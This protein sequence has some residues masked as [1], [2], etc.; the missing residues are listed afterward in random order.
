M[1]M[2][3]HRNWSKPMI[4]KLPR[5]GKR[6]GVRQSKK[7]IATKPDLKPSPI[8]NFVEH[9]LFCPLF[10]IIVI[11]FP[12]LL[13]RSPYLVLEISLQTSGFWDRWFCSLLLLILPLLEKLLLLLGWIGKSSPSIV[14]LAFSGFK[15]WRSLLGSFCLLIH[16]Q[17]VL[18]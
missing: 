1:I 4:T 6:N 2:T 7:K 8:S 12:V 3:F 15:A 14:W 17:I 16:R 18:R 13:P 9:Y 5:R 11:F 10:F